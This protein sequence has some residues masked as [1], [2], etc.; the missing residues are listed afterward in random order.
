MTR[1]KIFVEAMSESRY[2][3]RREEQNAEELFHSQSP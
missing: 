3:E 2:G 1:L